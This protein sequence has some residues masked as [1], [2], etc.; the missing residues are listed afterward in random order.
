M[1]LKFDGCSIGGPLNNKFLS[2]CAQRNGTALDLGK[3]GKFCCPGIKKDCYKIEQGGTC[4]KS[5]TSVVDLGN[6][7]TYCC[8]EPQTAYA[9]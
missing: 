2:E 1:S 8:R 3:S 7:G 4:P 5:A 6:A 9:R